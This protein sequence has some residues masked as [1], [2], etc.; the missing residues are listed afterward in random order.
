V[1]F[2]NLDGFYDPLIQMLDQMV[3][4]GFY[5][6]E[7]RDAL[8]IAETPEQLLQQLTVATWPDVTKWVR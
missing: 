5:R 2:L 1:G 7:Q 3:T 4:S 6:R 8:V